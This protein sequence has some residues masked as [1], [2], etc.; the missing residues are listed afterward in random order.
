MVE[1]VD[2]MPRAVIDSCEI[3]TTNFMI[4]INRDYFYH[5]QSFIWSST[6]KKNKKILLLL[7]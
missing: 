2:L 1:I 6:I 7:R 4:K 5:A 3:Y